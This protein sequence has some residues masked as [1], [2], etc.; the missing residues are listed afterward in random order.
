MLWSEMLTKFVDKQTSVYWPEI[1]YV[2]KSAVVNTQ[3]VIK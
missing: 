3:P 2:L 1:K